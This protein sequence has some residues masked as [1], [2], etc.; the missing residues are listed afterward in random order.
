M[1]LKPLSNSCCPLLNS[2][3]GCCY[4]RSKPF[5]SITIHLLIAVPLHHAAFMK[6]NVETPKSG[7]IDWVRDRCKDT[8]QDNLNRANYVR[9]QNSAILTHK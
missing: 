3:G 9:G 6:V 5:D 2:I 7:A 8:I 1:P 4:I